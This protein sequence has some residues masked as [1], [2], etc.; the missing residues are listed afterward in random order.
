MHLLF[1]IF[2]FSKSQDSTR[3]SEGLRPAR[4]DLKMLNVSVNV[5]VTYMSNIHGQLCTTSD[6]IYADRQ[7]SLSLACPV[8]L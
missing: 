4:L 3:T 6:R 1:V 7:T 5:N 2:R 8:P